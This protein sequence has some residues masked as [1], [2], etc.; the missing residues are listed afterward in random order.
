[1]LSCIIMILGGGGVCVDDEHVEDNF[2]D[3]L[4]SDW[5]LGL[6]NNAWFFYSFFKL[7]FFLI[8]KLISFQI[9]RKEKILEI[10]EPT[11]LRLTHPTRPM[12]LSFTSSSLCGFLWLKVCMSVNPFFW[13]GRSWPVSWLGASAKGWE[14]SFCD[15]LGI[16]PQNMSGDWGACNAFSRSFYPSQEFAPPE[17]RVRI[18]D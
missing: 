14:G 3:I 17:G 13:E 2:N 9:Y 7:L 18:L 12:S 15:F 4:I 1:M 11:N 6:M 10:T 16:C 8:E 5:S